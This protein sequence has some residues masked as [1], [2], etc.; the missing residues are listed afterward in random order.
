MKAWPFD[1]ARYE[2]VGVN[3]EKALARLEIALKQRKG[4]FLV[5][6]ELTIADIIVGG[7][8]WFAMRSFVDKEMRKAAPS[9]EGY[10]RGFL[11]LPEVGGTF[12]KLKLCERG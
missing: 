5:G 10:L 4:R 2:T 11:E 7:A 9:L 6:E 3:L 8:L 1:Q 12:R